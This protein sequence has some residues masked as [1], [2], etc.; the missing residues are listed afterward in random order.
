M[1]FPFNLHEQMPFSIC[2][3]AFHCVSLP[4]NAIYIKHKT[5]AS[6]G[7]G[8]VFVGKFRLCVVHNRPSQRMLGHIYLKFCYR[9]IRSVEWPLPSNLLSSPRTH[10]DPAGLPFKVLDT[11][12]LFQ[13]SSSQ[14]CC[15]TLPSQC[16]STDA[17]QMPL[18]QTRKD[19]TFNHSKHVSGVEMQLQ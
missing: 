11:W 1:T 16:M 19:A 8:T 12:L 2:R 4:A 6:S 7:G 15:K 18:P 17:I 5:R 10:V 9:H 3:G 14:L 13:G